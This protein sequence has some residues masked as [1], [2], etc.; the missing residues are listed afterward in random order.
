MIYNTRKNRKYRKKNKH[1]KTMKGGEQEKYKTPEEIMS[2][3]K[4]EH[5]DPVGDLSKKVYD[6]L[7]EI[8]KLPIPSLSSDSIADSKVVQS[9]TTLA[10]GVATNVV[11]KAGD[12]LGVDV[13][14]PEKVKEKLEN[15]NK[16][17]T[18]PENVEKVKELAGNLANVG[19]LGLEAAEPF[20]D[21]LV[22][23]VADTAQKG[24]EKT[25]KL[26][27]T[28]A[29]NVAGLFLGPIIDIPRTTLSA[30]EAG[31]SVINT[32]SEIVTTTSDTMN[33]AIQNFKQL[34]GQNQNLLDRTQQSISNFVNP[35]S[36]LKQ[37]QNNASQFQPQYQPQNKMGGTRKTKHLRKNKNKNHHKNH[38]N[39]S[40]KVRFYFD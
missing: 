1:N 10:E 5:S 19:L 11:E 7:P 40:K 24:L 33:A 6:S 8:P 2:E 22:D 14:N 20:I 36:I 30:L 25:G 37:N 31:Q 23:K 16:A 35:T 13:D 4:E 26:A 29:T 17:L 3:I 15:I 28:T 38:I 21:P 18:N 32:G 9:A 39:K 34:L 12:F 27:L